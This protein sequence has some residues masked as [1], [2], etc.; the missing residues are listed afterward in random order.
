MEVL[1]YRV[2]IKPDETEKY[3]ESGLQIVTDE[4][5]DKFNQQVGTIVSIGPQAWTDVANGTPWAGV[6]DR[7]VYAKY[8]ASW[9]V[10]P[11]T[12]DPITGKGDEYVLLADED[13]LCILEK[14]N[15]E[16]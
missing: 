7:V 6:G 5:L 10:D 11:E 15:K 9:I 12:Q 14:A 8:G 2:M 3:T 4:K 16:E 13:I 1:G